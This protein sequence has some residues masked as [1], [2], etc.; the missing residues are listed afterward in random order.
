LVHLI[1]MVLAQQ[2]E[3]AQYSARRSMWWL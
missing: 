3:V 1:G 2:H